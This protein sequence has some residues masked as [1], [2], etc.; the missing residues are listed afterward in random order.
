MTIFISV[1]L[2]YIS[3]TVSEQ[4]AVTKVNG[5]SVLV[6]E[7]GLFIFLNGRVMFVQSITFCFSD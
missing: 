7:M 6:L 1:V 3:Y 4:H 2:L 5:V